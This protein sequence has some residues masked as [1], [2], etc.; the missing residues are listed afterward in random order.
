MIQGSGLGLAI[1]RAHIEAHGG[2]LNLMEGI[3][4]ATCFQISL[5]VER[6]AADDES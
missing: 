1:A 5:P 6:E 3:K 4:S 2:K